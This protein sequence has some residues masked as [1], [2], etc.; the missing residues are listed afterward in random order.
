MPEYNEPTYALEN[1]RYAFYLD[2]ERLF[3]TEEVAILFD[4]SANTVLKHG[5]PDLVDGLAQKMRKAYLA[6]GFVDIANDCVVI[7]GKFDLEDL[8]KTVRI[9]DYIGKLYKKL[10]ALPAEAQSSP[11]LT[12]TT[13]TQ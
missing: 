8:N 7:Q 4:K 6:N 2:G 11:P 5:R 3:E 1:G 9:C 13:I 10:L 12:S